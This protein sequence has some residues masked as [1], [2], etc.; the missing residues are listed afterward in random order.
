[1]QTRIALVD[2]NNFYVS[3]ERIFRPDLWDRPVAVLSNNDGCIVARSQEVKDLGIKMGTPVFEIEKLIKR[4]RIQLFSSNYALY[5]DMSARVMSLLEEFSPQVEIYSIDEAFLNLTGLAHEDPIAYALNIR[6]SILQMTGITV[7]VGMGPTKTLAKLASFAAKKWLKTGGVLDLCDPVR[8]EKLIRLVPVREVW[9]VGSRLAQRLNELGIMTAW[10]LASQTITRIQG[11]FNITLAR[12]VME[13]NGVSCQTLDDVAADKQQ[14]VSSRSFKRR[15]TNLDE[16]AEALA[17]FCSRAAQKLR[18]QKSL[19]G[20]VT[21]FIRTNP[22]SDRDPYYQRAASLTL[23]EAT[24]DTRR[25]TGIAKQLL[26][27]IFKAGYRYQHCGVQLSDL[28]RETLPGQTDLFEPAEQAGSA[29]L[30]QT[31]DRINRRYH[32]KAVTLA[33]TGLGQR[34]QVPVQNV[35]G[36][37]TTDWDELVRVKCS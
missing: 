2:C 35:S 23:T 17:E 1:M 21:V 22:H 6:E 15:L 32:K 4:H 9:G 5:A 25:L 8:R 33:A 30:M 34:W 24:Q 31:V 12:T 19:A 14:I 28:R 16:L 26:E 18:Q 36:R 20:V 13:L 29:A 27:Q 7:C 11:Q 10:D 3:C 37:Y